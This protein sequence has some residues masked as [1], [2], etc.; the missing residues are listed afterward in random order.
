MKFKNVFL[1]VSL[2]FTGLLANEKEFTIKTGLADIA[3][4]NMYKGADDKNIVVPL[5]FLKYGDFY[6]EGLSLGYTLYNANALKVH[7]EVSANML[8]YES[9]E[10]SYLQGM[11]KREIDIQTGFKVAYKTSQNSELSS[12]IAYDFFNIHGGFSADLKY[13][14]DLFKNSKNIFTTYAGLEYLSKKKSDYYYGVRAYEANI[15]RPMYTLGETLNH[16]FGVK[17]LY[18][19]NQQW[20]LLARAEYKNFDKDIY[21]SP[22]VEESYVFSGFVGVLYAW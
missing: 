14:Y 7:L 1:L 19:F 10:S 12:K 15:L 3:H 13:S 9:G 22:I 11:D 21:K 16:Y 17:N 18:I 20:A 4:T 6:F 8:G 5:L 2:L